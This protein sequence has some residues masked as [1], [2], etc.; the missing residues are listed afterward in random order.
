M[1]E[2]EL[3]IY[4]SASTEMDAECEL[5]GRFLAEI[6]RS[7][8]W[9]IKRTPGQHENAN[10]DLETLRKSQFYLILMGVDITAPIGVELREAQQAGIPILAYRNISEVATPAAAFFIHNSG[11]VW[12]RYEGPQ[13]FIRD[14][15]R[16]LITRLVE[17]TPG[18]GLNLADIE[19]LSARLERLKESE[20]G[21]RTANDD[22]RRGAGRGG[23]IL[24]SD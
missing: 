9:I 2:N 19:D 14:L 12:R 15:E 13:A 8:R 6:T 11:V 3:V 16:E 20:E 21:I 17:G 7:T 10:P 1:P 5:L 4:V 18:Y 22:A 23:V 24:P